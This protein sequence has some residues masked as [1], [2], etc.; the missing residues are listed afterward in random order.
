MLAANGLHHKNISPRGFR[1]LWV[2]LLSFS[3][4]DFADKLCTWDSPLGAVISHASLGNPP[5]FGHFCHC[6]VFHGSLHAVFFTDIIPRYRQ[7]SNDSS[8]FQFLVFADRRHTKRGGKV[9]CRPVGVWSYSNSKAPV[10]RR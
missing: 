9:C 2:L 3:A 6:T 1:A 7:N 5:F 8:E 4:S 10:Y